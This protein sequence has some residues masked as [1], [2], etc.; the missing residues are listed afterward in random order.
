MSSRHPGDDPQVVSL[1]YV[2]QSLETGLSSVAFTNHVIPHVHVLRAAVKIGVVPDDVD[3][4]AGK[5]FLCRDRSTL[6]SRFT[7]PCPAERRPLEENAGLRLRK[8]E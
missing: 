4:C 1:A 8:P 5:P 6:T 2:H 7:E 3:G